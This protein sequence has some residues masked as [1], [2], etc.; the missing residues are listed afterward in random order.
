MHSS[1]EFHTAGD[2]DYFTVA[3]GVVDFVGVLE[4]LFLEL[5]GFLGLIFLV[6]S[7]K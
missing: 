4:S 7:L 3:A 2:V 5:F 6:G 1:W